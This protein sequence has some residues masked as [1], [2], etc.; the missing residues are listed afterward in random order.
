MA[1]IEIEM[2]SDVFGQFIQGIASVG[3]IPVGTVNG[4]GPGRLVAGFKWMQVNVGQTPPGFSPQ[5]GILTAGCTVSLQHLSTA[6]LDANPKASGTV[7]V[8][9][10]W[11]TITATPENLLIHLIAIT[12]PNTAVQWFTPPV[13][14]SWQKLPKFPR[15]MFV[16]AALVIKN[17]TVTLRFGTHAADSLLTDPANLVRTVDDQWAIHIPGDYFAET[18]LAAVNEAITKKPL[19]G[20]VSIED[21]PEASWEFNDDAWMAL[22]SVGL[23]KKNACPTILGA[24]DLSV[25]IDFKLTPSATTNPPSPQLMLALGLNSNASDWDTFRCWAGN[26]A[27]ASILLDDFSSPFVGAVQAEGSLFITAIGSLITLGEIIRLQAGASLSEVDPPD[28]TSTGRG[29]TFANFSNVLPLPSLVQTNSAG[30]SNGVINTATVGAYGMLISGSIIPLGADHRV[31]F[32]PESGVLTSQLKNKFDCGHKSWFREAIIPPILIEDKA[33]PAG[34]NTIPVQV[35]VFP[36]SSAVPSNLWTIDMPAPDI[37]QYVTIKGSKSIKPGDTGRVYLHTSAG[38]RRFDITAVPQ[39]AAP[40]PQQQIAAA[41]ACLKNTKVF[42]P[43]EKISWLPDPPQKHPS[44]NALRQ[45]LFVFPELPASGNATVHLASDKGPVENPIVDTGKMAGHVSFEVITNDS[46]DIS[47]QH[48]YQKGVEGRIVQRWIT[49]TLELDLGEPGQALSRNGNLITVH[50]ADSILTYDMVTGAVTRQSKQA[51]RSAHQSPEHP[52]FS[53]T[54][55]D[56][57]I[58]A[59]FKTKLLI[60]V[61]SEPVEYSK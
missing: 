46:T 35:K 4:L 26:G 17:D 5:P 29:D 38:L 15:A 56:G 54:L 58:A 36:S 30:Q 37:A 57:K 6:E 60:G 31:S 49:P 39:I 43:K 53:L 34:Q 3:A 42:N 52:P 18:L 19:P 21:S 23:L 51:G 48:T 7:T 45:W 12:I 44:F 59:L 50:L 28:F 33:L 47:I 13:L 55:P 32:S 2:V 27:I 8:A 24:V 22:G 25:S 40:T 41:L 61:P 1:V 20:G 16:A 14:V 11:I 10:A 9:T